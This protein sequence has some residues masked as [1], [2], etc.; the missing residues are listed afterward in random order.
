[1]YTWHKAK[2]NYNHYT[3]DAN[4]TKN[5]PLQKLFVEEMKIA[6]E[7]KKR[8]LIHKCES[9]KEVDYFKAHFNCN[10]SNDHPFKT[11]M[12]SVGELTR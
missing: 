1:M 3:T 12:M 4:V 2:Q 5:Y 7:Q 8:L 10:K 11:S 6:S 9:M